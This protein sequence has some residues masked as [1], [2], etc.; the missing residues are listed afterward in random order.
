MELES[1]EHSSIVQQPV[2]VV[3]PGLA[4]NDPTPRFPNPHSERL[5]IVFLILG[6]FLAFAYAVVVPPFQVPDED[7][8]LW[9]AYSVSDLHLMGPA[10]TQ[11]PASFVRLHERFPP[12]L[13][14]TPEKRVVRAAELIK[15]LR[16][17]LQSSSTAGIE[18]PRANLYSFVPYLTTSLVLKM[19][20]PAECSP[21]L[22]LY[23]GRLANAAV[24][25]L[26]L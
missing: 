1:P 22:L 8:H 6:A 7:R 26:L 15:W 12:W 21:L 24:Y 11:I 13:I 16:Q 18:N 19:G 2:M 23:A 25:L 5:P 3:Q 17:P 9:R 10:R 4:L 20:R 14:D